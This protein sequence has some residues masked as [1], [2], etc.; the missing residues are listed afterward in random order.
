MSADQ[1]QN[2]LRK[3]LEALLKLPDNLVCADCK[4]R[5]IYIYSLFPIL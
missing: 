3:R 5:G 1:L 4:R 2:K